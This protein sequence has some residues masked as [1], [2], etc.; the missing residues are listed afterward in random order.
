M[1]SF[2]TEDELKELG[3]KSFGKN[4]QISRKTSIYGADKISIGD[5]V[6]IDD[7]CF[8]SGNITIGNYVHIAVACLLYG[9]TAGIEMHDFSGLSP[10]I[11]IHSDS[12]DYSGES[13]TNPTTPMKYKNHFAAKVVLKRHVIIGSGST[14]LP[15]VIMEE[16][17]AVGAMSLVSKSTE[18]WSIYA[19]IPAK[20]VKDRS[21]NLL[22]FEKELLESENEI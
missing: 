4:V 15:G 14:I 2:Y 9:G 19:G 20:R 22:K 10:R 16:G 18:P 5:N 1:S 13:L 21:K 3:L 6:R 11:T 8:L 12:E 17:G 7:Y